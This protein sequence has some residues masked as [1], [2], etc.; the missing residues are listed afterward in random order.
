MYITSQSKDLSVNTISLTSI[1]IR[2]LSFADESIN[3]EYPD[4]CAIYA[5]GKGEKRYLLGVYADESSA[6]REIRDIQ[7]AMKSSEKIYQMF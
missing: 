7:D 3:E 1:E 6:E 4:A 2:P 5:Y